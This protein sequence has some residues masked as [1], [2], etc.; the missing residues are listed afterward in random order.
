MDVSHLLYPFT[1][2]WTFR[3]VFLLKPYE[4]KTPYV[5]LTIISQNL[6]QC[7][8]LIRNSYFGNSLAVQWLGLCAFTV[9][10]PGW[11]P[12]QGTDSTSLPVQ[13]KKKRFIFCSTFKKK[14]CMNRY[15]KSE[16]EGYT[17]YGL[18]I[19]L[20]SRGLGGVILFS[21]QCWT[22]PLLSSGRKL[23]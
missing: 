3:L 20:L 7:L 12:G 4:N 18:Y 16:L 17:T 5:L 1:S 19:Y 23:G 21:A 6:V 13:P 11:I 15:I 14:C 2:C 9:G 10:G 8:A 22:T